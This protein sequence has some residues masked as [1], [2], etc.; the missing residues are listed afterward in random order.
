MTLLGMIVETK[1]GTSPRTTSALPLAAADAAG[2][3]AGR[4]PARSVRRDEEREDAAQGRGL[5]CT[6]QEA[7]MND[8]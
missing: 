6:P 2:L 8:E 1:S 5:T 7:R 3:I 4:L